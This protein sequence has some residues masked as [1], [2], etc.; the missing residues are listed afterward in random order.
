M[1]ISEKLVNTCI[2]EVPFLFI[3]GLQ[4]KAVHLM[5]RYMEDGACLHCKH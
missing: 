3:I 5:S 4:L 1:T 2:I